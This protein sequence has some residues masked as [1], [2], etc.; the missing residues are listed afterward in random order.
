MPRSSAL[1]LL[2]P[3]AVGL[4]A[5]AACSAPPP[6]V[7]VWDPQEA[8]NRE[9]H[10]LNQ[11]LDGLIA[12]G[13]GGASLPAPVTRGATNFANNAGAPSDT[14]NSL[15]QG[16]PGPAI[17]NGLRFLI[18]TSFGIGGLFDMATPLGIEGRRTDFGETLHVW[19]V[20]EGAYQ[21]LPLLGPSTERDTAGRIVDLLIDPL[22]A[23]RPPGTRNRLIVA[24]AGTRGVAN[25]GERAA[26]AEAIDALITGSVDSYASTR[27][28]YLQTRRFRLDGAAALS[29][30]GAAPFDPFVD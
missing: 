14:L 15:L 7:D 28:L 29:D 21:E 5:L 30:D 2:L 4:A 8:Q 17:E 6:G 25:L 19:G 3:A 24:R 11:R 18:N 26:Y 22:N 20:R 23:L 9:A 12:G 1:H 13:G 16:R 10:A 27:L